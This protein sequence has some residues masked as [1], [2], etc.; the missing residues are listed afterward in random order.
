MRGRV[1]M[2]FELTVKTKMGMKMSMG[3]KIMMQ[4]TETE[5]RTT[6]IMNWRERKIKPTRKSMK[7]THLLQSKKE[8][9]MTMRRKLE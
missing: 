4:M 5:K 6:M 7:R 1:R 8:M 3:L 9:R 2:T